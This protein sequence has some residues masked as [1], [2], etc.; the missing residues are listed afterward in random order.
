MNQVKFTHPETGKTLYGQVAYTGH[1]SKE[2]Q[3]E[4]GFVLVDDAVLPTCYE[5]P[6]EVLTEIPFE[7]GTYDP[8]TH[9]WEG[10]DEYHTYI[11]NEFK[12]AR[13]RSDAL[14]DEFKPGKLFN[15]QVADG[16]AYYV[17]TKVNKKTC[18]IE[19]RGFC[20]DR[21]TDS[22]LGLGGRFPRER[23]EQLV[24]SM[25]G[26]KRLFAGPNR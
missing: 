25:D 10:Q 20:P 16:R 21:W 12:K 11:K 14:G 8:K 19:W 4:E 18:D 15:T 24:R 23:I 26:L 5:V 17:V 7:M 22:V 6:E 1:L 13:E 2:E 9:E 3:P